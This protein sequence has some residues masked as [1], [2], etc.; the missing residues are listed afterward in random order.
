MIK[1]TDITAR[2]FYVTGLVVLVTAC[3]WLAS[4]YLVPIAVAIFV[5]LLINAFSGSLRRLPGIGPHLP[6]WLAR[7]F[8]IVALFAL[9]TISVR[10]I[11]A[12]I[13]EL[14]GGIPEGQSVLLG[15]IEAAIA[16]LGLDLNL[17]TQ[18]VLDRLAVDQLI[19]WALRLAQG[20]ISDVA[21]VFLYVL[22]LLIDE[23]FFQQKL[24]ALFPDPDRRQDLEASIRRI[25]TEVRLYLWLMTLVSLGVALMT[26]IACRATGVS[27]AGFW[28]FLAFALNFVPTIGSITAVVLPALYGLLIL[29]DPTQLAILITVLAATQF[30]AGEI[31]LPRLMGS[32]LNLSSFVILL[33]LVIWGALWGPAGM[34]MAIPITVS[35]VLIAARFDSTRPIAIVLSKDG[36]IPDG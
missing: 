4:D 34:F 36:S 22:F 7:L 10:I 1:P 21:L 6:V 14:G 16:K 8:A 25:G 9:I 33:T 26:Y 27:G 2:T 28:A 35:L 30:V 20:L 11:A 29:E 3:L 18:D 15:R 23:R 5:Y 12:N 24:K 31:V 19:G 32:K 13:A 17:T